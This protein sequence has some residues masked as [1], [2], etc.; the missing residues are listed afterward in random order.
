MHHSR[1]VHLG[2][3]FFSFSELEPLSSSKRAPFG[4][5]SAQNRFFYLPTW[6]YESNNNTL[7]YFLLSILY[8]VPFHYLFFICQSLKLRLPNSRVETVARRKKFLRYDSMMTFVLWE[9]FGG[10]FSDSNIYRLIN[11]DPHVERDSF[12]PCA[13]RAEFYHTLRINMAASAPASRRRKTR[14]VSLRLIEY[15]FSPAS[16]NDKHYTYKNQAARHAT[17]KNQKGKRVSFAIIG[18]NYYFKYRSRTQ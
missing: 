15:F 9:L 4:C 8:S 11:R 7:T 16:S 13:H 18:H 6:K 2:C 10:W 3:F 12:W 17:T 14:N 1:K 5:Q